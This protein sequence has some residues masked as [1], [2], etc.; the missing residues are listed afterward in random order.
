MLSNKTLGAPGPAIDVDPKFRMLI[1]LTMMIS[2]TKGPETE[3][4]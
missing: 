2:P 4:P 1:N 3:I